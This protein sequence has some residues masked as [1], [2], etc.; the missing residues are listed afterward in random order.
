MSRIQTVADLP[1]L[2]TLLQLNALIG[3]PHS[4]CPDCK[5]CHFAIT[6]RGESICRDC[7]PDRAEASR[8]IA[9]RI[10]VVLGADGRPVALDHQKEQRR[11]ELAREA[12]NKGGVVFEYAG[13]DWV[14]WVR[15][16]GGRSVALLDGPGLDDCKEKLR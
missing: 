14:A 5:G 2:L 8:G 12:Y 4:P 6:N 16:D 11:L 10:V 13:Q 3:S 1:K 15:E 9:K 7:D